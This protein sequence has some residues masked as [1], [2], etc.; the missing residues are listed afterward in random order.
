MSLFPSTIPPHY[1]TTPP[2][3]TTPP[4]PITP[5]YK[6]TYPQILASLGFGAGSALALAL[7]LAEQKS[8]TKALLLS[9]LAM[10]FIGAGNKIFSKLSTIPMQR[11]GAFLSLFSTGVYLISFIW[12]W[13]NPKGVI[14]KEMKAVPK[15]KFAVM[16][17]LDS[18]A[19]VMQTFAVLHLK[20][21]A[22]IVLL[23]Q[24]AIPVSL[25]IS[26]L[27][28]NAKY[29]IYNYVGAL[30]VGIGLVVVLLPSFLHPSGSEPILWIIIMILSCVPMALSSV[31]KEIA[32]NDVDLDVIF[33]NGWIA[34]FQL[35]FSV[36]L[37]LPATWASNIPIA[38]LPKYLIYGAKCY[39][40]IN[41]ITTA[42]EHYAPDDCRMAPAY[43]N[44]YIFGFNLPFNVLILLIL[45][46]GSANV[47]WLSLTTLVPIAAFAF[48]LPFV[49]GHKPIKATDVIGLV[50]IMIGLFIYRVLGLVLAWREERK[51]LA[52]G[53]SLPS[54]ADDDDVLASSS[55][56][57]PS[58]P[59]GVINDASHSAADSSEWSSLRLSVTPSISFTGPSLEVGLATG[60]LAHQVRLRKAHQEKHL[61]RS[62]LRI[63]GGYFSKLGLPA[64]RVAGDPGAIRHT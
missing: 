49:P 35:L 36:P 13:I 62:D 28:L 6:L 47:L 34:L 41:S 45:S 24:V 54:S 55:A 38:D 17:M 63:R 44:L 22:L 26:K 8:N 4:S 2:S 10:N 11:Y 29:K 46:V 33:M 64:A 48:A 3:S 9:F 50:I 20:S 52:E 12:V 57:A 61:R 43:V 42:N 56:L 19:G 32:L 1:P 16:G 53:G 51:A 18:M 7:A 5:P 40:G 59:V 37:L 39:V 27:L 25:V 60:V 58:R 31:Y 21:G 14:T 15:Y 23:Q 30:V